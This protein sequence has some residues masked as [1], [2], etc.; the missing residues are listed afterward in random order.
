MAGPAADAELRAAVAAAWGR[1]LVGRG[2]RLPGGEESAAHRFGDLVVR[3][4]PPWRGTAEAEWCHAVALAAAAGG[5]PAVVRPERTRDGATV[6]RIGGRPV[7]LWPYAAGAPADRAD[8][9]EWSGAARELAGLHRALVRHRPP[10]R[11]EPALL[12]R[13]LRGEPWSGP[14]ALADAALSRWLA[15]FARRRGPGQPLHGDYYR[16][17]VLARGGRIVAVLDFDEAHIG[18]PELEVATAGREFGD[19]WATDLSGVRRFADAYAA[20]G[21][22]A[23]RMDDE[24]TAQLIRHRLRCEAAHVEAGGGGAEDGRAPGAADRA[25]HRRRIDL[26]HRLRP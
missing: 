22:T 16:G 23:G 14:A 20:A 10:P 15:E 12:E 11:P 25:Y 21:G 7:S 9:G 19:P 1:R 13:G 2:E 8:R 18:P 3:I 17:N 5:A 26:F 4:G 6:V 24:T